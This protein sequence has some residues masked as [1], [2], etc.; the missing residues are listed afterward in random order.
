MRAMKLV[1]GTV[2]VTLTAFGCGVRG[3]AYPYTRAVIG[4]DE[5]WIAF[6]EPPKL[7]ELEHG[8]YVA[9]DHYAAVYYTEDRYWLYHQGIWYGA[10]SWDSAW[11]PVHVDLV[12][13]RIAYR[14]HARYVRYRPEDAV[15][16]RAPAR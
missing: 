1:I 5:P 13:S 15:V 12:P 14:D 2:L 7:V 10:K 9:R 6:R 8:L 3:H 16:Q 4:Y 11:A